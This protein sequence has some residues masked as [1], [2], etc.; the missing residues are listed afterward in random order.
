M[1]FSEELY[2]LACWDSKDCR[3]NFR[4]S[5]KL[6]KFGIKSECVEWEE[7]KRE[8][9]MNEQL[10]DYTDSW[11]TTYKVDVATRGPLAQRLVFTLLLDLAHLL[12]L[13]TTITIGLPE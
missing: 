13:Y 11:V 2:R 9:K 6:V 1:V 12:M 4:D 3:R 7:Q 8:L 10:P 5:R